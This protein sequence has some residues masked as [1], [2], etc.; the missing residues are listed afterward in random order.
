MLLNPARGP[1]IDETALLAAL[2]EGWIAGA[3]LDAHYHYPMPPEHPLWSM[4][5][6]I[7]T[8]H[9]SGSSAGR[10]FL[11]RVWEL[12]AE[13]LARYLAGRPLLNELSAD[14]LASVGAG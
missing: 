6:V 12:F 4:P 14:E 1:L 3:A 5:N 8:P 11:P 9:I 10:A 2:R 7:L 13:N